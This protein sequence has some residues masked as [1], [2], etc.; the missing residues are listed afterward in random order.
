[1]LKFMQNVGGLIAATLVTSILGS[2]FSTQS[3]IASL[4]A[5]NVDVPLATRLS[6][7]VSDLN[8]L[9][10]LGPITAICFIVGFIIAG[11]AHGYF[12][13]NR[14]AWYVIAGASAL[15]TTLLIIKSILLITAIAGTRTPLGLMSFALA[16]AVG[17]WVYAKLTTPKVT[18]LKEAS[19]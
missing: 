1:M 14:T 18:T 4:A 9:I 8:I 3:V 15:I 16:G 10:A 7:T 12:G 6:M 2:I 5:I 17:G 13:G 19:L 11:L